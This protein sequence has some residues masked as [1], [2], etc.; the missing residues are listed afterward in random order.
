MRCE[1][2][3]TWGFLEICRLCWT[4]PSITPI[5]VGRSPYAIPYLR[6]C[7]R[8]VIGGINYRVAINIKVNR[9]VKCCFIPMLLMV[10]FILA[11]LCVVFWNQQKLVLRVKFNESYS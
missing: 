1:V 6:F 4:H 2:I 8:D 11:A 10:P 9:L 3:E 7:G 5:F